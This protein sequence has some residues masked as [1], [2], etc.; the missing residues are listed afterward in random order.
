MSEQPQVN[1]VPFP[2]GYDSADVVPAIQF[3]ALQHTGPL[4]TTQEED[5]MIERFWTGLQ[6]RQKREGKAVEDPLRQ[7]SEELMRDRHDL[8]KSHLK[9]SWFSLAHLTYVLLAVRS[10]LLSDA[11]WYRP[12]A[13]VPGI[14]GA[15]L[16]L[17]VDTSEAECLD[18]IDRF[19]PLN[20]SRRGVAVATL[21]FLE[22]VRFLHRAALRRRAVVSPGLGLSGVGLVYAEADDEAAQK[23][24]AFLT[25]HGI[26]VIDRPGDLE[27]GGRVLVLFS[28][29]ATQTEQFWDDVASWKSVSVSPMVLCL[30]SRTHLYRDKPE[31][32]DE[33]L[34]KWLC[35]TAAIELERADEGYAVLLR[36]LDSGDPRRWWWSRHDTMDISFTNDTMDI[37]FTNDLLGE[38]VPRPAARRT[39]VDRETMSYPYGLD[40]TILPVCANALHSAY[41]H[42]KYGL[43]PDPRTGQHLPYIRI[44]DE[45]IAKR[46]EWCGNPF[47]LPWFMLAYRV[48]LAF[49]A[50]ET[51]FSHRQD[52]A[53]A[54]R[55]IRRAL[56]ALGVYAPEGRLADFM[57]EFQGLP[58]EQRNDP[59]E[60][61]DERT[62]TFLTL[63]HALGQFA[64]TTGQT[65]QLRFP[66]RPCFVSYSRSDESLAREILTRLEAKGA[67]AWFDL[68]SLTL[69]ASLD[70]AL[71]GA[72]RDA[73]L[74]FVIASPD[75]DGSSYVRREI[76]TALERGAKVV[77]F[78]SKGELPPRIASLLASHPGAAIEPIHVEDAPS[79]DA[80][81]LALSYLERT[82]GELLDWTQS[83]EVYGR[84]HDHITVM[85]RKLR[86]ADL[87]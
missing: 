26:P 76:K 19:V 54:D 49:A 75:A 14:R 41:F 36:A 1:A 42:A 43:K 40:R 33:R 65:V 30:T 34:W 59:V 62:A 82:P 85:R 8:L 73:Q 46:R 20:A 9:L 78:I 45:L 28:E 79:S 71:C 15:L 80:I 47:A 72:A 52:E 84:I 44:C 87:D 13:F 4:S 55:E 5:K 2:G 31:R 74:L 61:V 21:T 37:S 83:Q 18:E 68:T 6:D 86:D 48:W 27:S 29:Q 12:D 81:G 63:V 32:A 38:G 69:G 66:Q 56:V 17:G 22:F 50:E 64:L 23:I 70:E 60:R 39:R 53:I 24:H 57:A 3:A 11:P 35:D 67:V 7:R 77:P 10:S 58:W 16:E 51:E 25:K